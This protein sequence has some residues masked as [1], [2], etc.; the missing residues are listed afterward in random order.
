M[1][2]AHQFKRPIFWLSAAL[3]LLGPVLAGWRTPTVGASLMLTVAT[4]SL[5]ALAA[6]VAVRDRSSWLV[7][8]A[9]APCALGLF[10][11]VLV[12]RRFDFG[13]LAT[14]RGDHWITGGA[15]AIAALA[16]ASIVQGARALTT[17][18]SLRG[19]LTGAALG[20]WGLTMAWLPALVIAEAVRPRLGY[21]VRRWS[22]VFPVG[23]Y[24][25]CSFMVGHTARADAITSFARA[26]VWVAVAVWAAVFAAMLGRAVRA[27]CRGRRPD[28]TPPT[29]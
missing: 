7:V 12:I 28:A 1:V 25:A 9:L 17:L 6:P 18:T 29:S 20:L 16:T 11:Y 8:A 14:G 15:L 27:A 21:D 22:T 23:M 5:A 24:A 19:A 13:Q 2:W 26:W 10:F 3:S 4:E